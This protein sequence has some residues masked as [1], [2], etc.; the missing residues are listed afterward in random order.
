MDHAVLHATQTLTCKWNGLYLPL[1]HSRR[2]WGVKAH[3]GWYS[4]PVPL[5][6]GGWV[7]LSSLVKYSLP[8]RTPKTVTHPST[9][10]AW[11]RATSLKHPTML[12]L[13]AKPHSA[14]KLS[15][16]SLWRTCVIGVQRVYSVSLKQTNCD[17]RSS[18]SS[19]V[20]LNFWISQGN[21]YNEVKRSCKSLP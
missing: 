14:D 20:S 9:N 17:G 10:G 2:G 21:I 16:S 13:Y 15:S 19:V 18:N 4:F 6:V 1:H 5:R 11:R 7:G 8:V 3:F 12:P